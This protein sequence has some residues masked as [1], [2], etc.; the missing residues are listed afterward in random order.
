MLTVLVSLFVCVIV[1]GR[2]HFHRQHLKDFEAGNLSMF[3][4]HYQVLHVTI[5][6]EYFLF[7]GG[8]FDNQYFFSKHSPSSQSDTSVQYFI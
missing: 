2:K 7:P 3:F 4:N 6:E 1:K 5:F 8:Y